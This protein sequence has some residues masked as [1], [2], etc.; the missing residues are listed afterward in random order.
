VDVDQVTPEPS[1]FARLRAFLGLAVIVAAV[2][3]SVAVVVA[4]GAAWVSH[5]LESAVQ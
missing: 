2:G 3:L 4:A 1:L 5:T